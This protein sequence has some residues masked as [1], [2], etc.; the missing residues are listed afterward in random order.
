MTATPDDQDRRNRLSEASSPYLL[1]HAENPVAWRPWGEEAFREARERDVP[2]FISI[3]YS[4]CHWC[5]VMAHESFEDDEVAE[6]LNAGFVPVKVDRE[7]R[8]DVDNVYMTACQMM[9]GGGGWPLTVVATPDGEPFFTGTYFPKEQ[10]GRRPGLLQILDKLSEM[11]EEDREEVLD[12]ADRVTSA[13]RDAASRDTAGAE[14]GP[15]ALETAYRQLKRRHDPDEGGFGSEPKFPSAHNLLFLLRHWDRTGEEDALEMVRRTLVAMRRGGI[16]DQVGGGFHR[17]STDARWL[18]PHFEKMLYDQALLATAYVEAWQATGDDRFAETARRT[19][20]YVIRDLRDPE[21]GFHS[22]EDADSEG[23]EG[24]FYVWTEDELQEVLEPEEF[25]LARVVWNTRGAGNF[26][27]EATGQRTGEN[28][29]HRRTSLEALAEERDLDPGRLRERLERIREKLFRVREERPRPHRD[30]KVLTDWNGLAV[31]ALARAGAALGERD[32]VEAASGAAEFVL[33]RLRTED[34]R[35]L[36]RWREGEADI[37]ANSEDYAFLVWG[38][39]EL[40]EATLELRWLREAIRLQGEMDERCRDP[41]RGGYY[42]AAEDAGTPLVRQKEAHDGAIP[43]ANAVTHWNLV[44]LSRLTGDVEREEDALELERAFA[45]QVEQSPAGHVG[46]LVGVDARVGD[47]R[48][49]VLTGPREDEAMGRMLR[50]LREGFRPRTVWLYRPDGDGAG[51]LADLAPFTREQE[52]VDGRATAYVCRDFTCRAP[53][54]DP[55]EM[56]A[57][58]DGED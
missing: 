5:H 44:R 48:E 22:A 45:G 30:D 9:T 55:G 52:P 24:K 1:Q 40:Y 4:T 36:H 8:P 31:G 32:F 13:L 46:L 27:E 15:E 26:A 51:D 3:G 38:L 16:F 56:A 43:S 57:A 34:G 50:T 20:R 33:D 53:T 21:G 47:G 25:G 49:V 41:E 42:F 2:L 23:G 18:L 11:W 17:Y 19:L 37:P 12:S 39:L 35:L 29:L 10:R 6:V 14:L 7:E 54:T 28:I 58:L